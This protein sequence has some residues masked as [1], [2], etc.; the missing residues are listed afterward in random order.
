M[1]TAA[2]Y[3]GFLYQIFKQPDA[4]AVR[5]RVGEP[6]RFWLG[7]RDTYGYISTTHLETLD[8]QPKHME[9]LLESVPEDHSTRIHERG[10]IGAF[11]HPRFPL[12][13]YY[14]NRNGEIELFYHREPDKREFQS[15]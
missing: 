8:I 10:A 3:D 9:K 15:V 11:F 13:V 2:E 4:I 6:P 7:R 12:I 1:S 14:E 5:V